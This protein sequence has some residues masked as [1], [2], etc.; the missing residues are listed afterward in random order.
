MFIR[1]VLQSPRDQ[2]DPA[3]V[4]TDKAAPGHA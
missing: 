1:A 2:N 4:V 3:R